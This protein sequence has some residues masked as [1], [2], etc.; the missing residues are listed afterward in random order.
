M[1]CLY[2]QFVDEIKKNIATV[3]YELD[4]KFKDFCLI[5]LMGMT[6]YDSKL[7]KLIGEYND[8]QIKNLEESIKEAFTIFNKNEDEVKELLDK[9]YERKS[10]MIELI[11]E[12]EQK[13]DE[14][15]KV[16]IKKK[17]VEKKK[18][19]EIQIIVKNKDFKN[20]GFDF[21]KEN[22]VEYTL[23]NKKFWTNRAVK[24]KGVNQDLKFN[25]LTNLVIYEEG[26]S[27]ILYGMLISDDSDITFIKVNE[28][29][30]SII[31]WCKKSKIILKS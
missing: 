11:E 21:E 14:E 18:N 27:T 4:K 20:A 25:K 5:L 19:M 30:E 2:N 31:E 23:K 1:N 22:P 28:L 26:D 8:D 15:N 12:E 10:R 6:S 17:K 16:L 9:I 7:D 13:S 24:I 29:D 3:T